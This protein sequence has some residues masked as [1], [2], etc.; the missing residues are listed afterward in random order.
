MTYFK[1]YIAYFKG[2]AD[3][4]L[5]NTVDNKTFYRRGLDEFLNGLVTE[6]N[7]PCML[8]TEYDFVFSDNGFDDVKKNR[9]VAFMIIDHI[10]DIDD[11]DAKDTAFD[12]AEKIVDQIYNQ[13]RADKTDSGQ[14]DF[15]QYAET[16]NVQVTPI[17]M[18]TNG[19]YGFYVTINLKS[20]H[21]VTI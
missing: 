19:D 1:D 18:P 21:N 10:S 14:D 20:H 17:M 9:T 16:N 4:Y 8:L 7:Y 6:V 12:N 11:F 15:I 5:A 13:I 3:T 2:L